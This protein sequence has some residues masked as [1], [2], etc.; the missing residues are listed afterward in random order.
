VIDFDDVIAAG[1]GAFGEFVTWT[2]AGGAA[3]TV[4][5]V[6]WDNATETNFE[7]GV[8]VVETVPLLSLRLS[9]MTGVPK[10]ADAFTV[11]GVAYVATQVLPDG[12]GGCRV[13]MRYAND[14]Q[15]G[16]APLPPVP[17]AS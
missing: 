10:Q 6:F 5:A 8:E 17:V 12:V 15:A 11:R 14:A 7:D 9:Q 2:P 13:R 16:V 1:M 3:Q 4:P